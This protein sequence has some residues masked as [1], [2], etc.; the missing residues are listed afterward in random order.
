MACGRYAQ[1]SVVLSATIDFCTRLPSDPPPFCLSHPASRSLALRARSC[2]TASR[3]AGWCKPPTESTFRPSQALLASVTWTPNARSKHVCTHRVRRHFGPLQCRWA[4]VCRYPHRHPTAK[5][6][7]ASP[8]SSAISSRYGR[9]QP[10]PFFCHPPPVVSAP[11][12]QCKAAPLPLGRF[13]FLPP[14]STLVPATT[15]CTQEPACNPAER[16]NCAA[17]HLC[18]RSALAAAG[19]S[20]RSGA[21]PRHQQRLFSP[22][23][24]FSLSISGANDPPRILRHV[25]IAD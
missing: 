21:Y 1:A 12:V 2:L 23:A 25:C 16:F 15:D 9:H 24:S 8:A 20:A 19:A 6:P 5:P 4:T 11:P 22:T 3:R 10:T 17:G 13:A 18:S 14:N 7:V